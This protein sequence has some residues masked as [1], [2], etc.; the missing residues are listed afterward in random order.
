M[1]SVPSE[2]IGSVY[3][4]MSSDSTS[5]RAQYDTSKS[6]IYKALRNALS[7]FS[8]NSINSLEI[9][10]VLQGDPHLILHLKFNGKDNCLEFLRDYRERRVHHHVQ[11]QLRRCLSLDSLQV[12]LELKV[13]NKKLD[14]ILDEE[15]KCLNHIYSLK[16]SYVKDEDLVELETNFIN[17]SLGSSHSTQNSISPTS[18]VENSTQVSPPLS[19]CSSS[20]EPS[21]FPFQGRDYADKPLTSEHQQRFANLVGRSWKK[22][23][24]SLK[25]NCR[26]L[27]D[28]VID[29]IAYEHD[30]EGLYEQ[31]YQ[32]LRR[33]MDGEGKKATLKRLVDALVECELNVIA[34]KLLSMEDI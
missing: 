18:P 15:E 1:T 27:E 33:F 2:W 23:G 31:A 13:D 19:L 26:A 25:K 32:L 22:V 17:L 3:L 16:P 34:E 7:A 10:K 21:T 4:F 8:R 24:R 30:K 12:F 20:S 5:L 9:L 11:E 14:L 6:L 28:P 29:N